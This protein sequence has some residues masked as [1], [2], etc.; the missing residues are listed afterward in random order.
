MLLILNFRPLNL[1]IR[2]LSFKL[3]IHMVSISTIL[4][5]LYAIKKQK[6]K[7]VGEIKINSLFCA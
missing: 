6:I 3:Y 2:S 7:W 5:S 4:L 1:N